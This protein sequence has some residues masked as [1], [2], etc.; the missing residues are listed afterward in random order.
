[1]LTND[2][3]APHCAP[4]ARWTP[5]DEGYRT[6][7]QPYNEAA[8]PGRPR[9]IAVPKTT[10]QVLEVITRAH[11][12]G[13]GVSVHST[14]HDFEGR[15]LSGDVVLHLGAFTHA[16]YD[17]ARD[18]LTVGG[19]ARVHDINQ[20][21]ARHGRAI[22][23]GTNQDVGIT[24]LTLGGGAAYTS[25]LHGLT[26]DALVEVELCTFAGEKLWVNDHSDPQ[27]MRLLR[28]GG[29]GRFGVIT[30]LKFNT[31][32]M[33]PVTK[34]SAH[35]AASAG[36]THLAELENLLVTAPRELSMRV[37]ANVT[38]PERT[39]TITLSGQVQGG[40]EALLAKHFGAFS[41]APSWTHETLPYYEAMAGA[42]HQTSG[43]SF[44]IKSRFA[45]RPVGQHGLAEM[46]AR[47]D[48][49]TP[50]RNADGAG[51]GLFAWG[52]RIRDF[53]E[54]SSCMPGRAAEYLASFDAAWTPQDADA[55][56]EAQLRW[57]GELDAVAAGHLSDLSYIN[58]PDSDDGRFDAR[59][60]LPALPEIKAAQGLHDPFGVGRHTSR[61]AQTPGRAS[62]IAGG[63]G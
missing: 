23:T 41:R 39:T 19:G 16:A 55:D 6:T 13:L 59:H 61:C 60:L 25:R 49:W 52:G 10:E 38:G 3:P 14:G 58:F 63:Q 35:W 46:L 22:S 4:F 47:L 31:Y 50:T 17:P 1:M 51:F 5:T 53:S 11:A 43:G 28:G 48:A 30:E 54:A 2:A 37:G 57:V 42:L 45:L 7:I 56:V 18:I 36:A 27:L 62:T 9:Y 34:F 26:C 33:T 44:K 24:G 29:G 8:A 12:D 15:S 40:N 21:L 32:A 20:V